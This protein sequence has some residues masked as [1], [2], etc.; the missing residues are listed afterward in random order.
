MS[1]SPAFNIASSDWQFCPIRKLGRNIKQTRIFLNGNSNIPQG[2]QIQVFVKQIPINFFKDNPLSNVPNSIPIADQ[3]MVKI[4]EAKNK[5]HFFQR[6][7]GSNFDGLPI[8]FF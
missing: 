8:V 5:T 2:N 4:P 7:T 6:N 1:C 3:Q